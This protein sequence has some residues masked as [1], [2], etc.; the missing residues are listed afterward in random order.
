MKSTTKNKTEPKD[1]KVLYWD[2]LGLHKIHFSWLESYNDQVA[3]VDIHANKLSN[4]PINFFELL[5]NLE[6]LDVSCNTI[7]KL[8]EDGIEDLRLDNQAV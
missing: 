4:L 8:P 7:D 5:P 2:N 6:D 1:S 3:R